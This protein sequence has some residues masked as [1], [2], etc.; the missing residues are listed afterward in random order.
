MARGHWPAG[1]RWYERECAWLLAEARQSRLR[2][3]GGPYLNPYT[4]RAVA[5]RIGVTHVTISFWE[6]CAHAPYCLDLWVRWARAVGEDFPALFAKVCAQ[7][8]RAAA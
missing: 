2:A 6:S 4:Q 7:A 3:A 1:T 8:G 5:E